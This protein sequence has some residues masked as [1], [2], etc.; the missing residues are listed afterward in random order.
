M[1]LNF[2]LALCD[3]LK[4]IC[5]ISTVRPVNSK[6]TS[7]KTAHRRSS[8]AMSRQHKDKQTSVKTVQRGSSSAMYR[9][10]KENT[11]IVRGPP[12]FLSSYT[13]HLPLVK[14]AQA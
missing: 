8:S 13:A 1:K 3:V 6:Q 2:L 10:R 11:F 4:H 7:V 12:F 14:G 5:V 9:Q